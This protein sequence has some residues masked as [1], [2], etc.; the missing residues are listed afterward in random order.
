MAKA[1]RGQLLATALGRDSTPFD[2]RPPCVKCCHLARTLPQWGQRGQRA[3]H[4]QAT[5]TVTGQACGGIMQGH[6]GPCSSVTAGRESRGVLIPPFSTQ[7]TNVGRAPKKC[8]EPKP[9]QEKTA[10]EARSK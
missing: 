10:G 8:E 3:P 2:P 6:A 1:A 4:T 9:T 7:L 5:C